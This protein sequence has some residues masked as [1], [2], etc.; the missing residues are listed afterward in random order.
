MKRRSR[1]EWRRV[2]L[3]WCTLPCILEFPT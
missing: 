2:H 1:G 3:V